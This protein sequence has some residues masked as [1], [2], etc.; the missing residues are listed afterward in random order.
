MPSLAL[1]GGKPVRTRPYPDYNTIG[2]EEKDAVMQ[3]MDSGILSGYL[4][5]WSP[6]FYGGPMV[7][8]LERQWEE[9]FNIAHAVSV[10]SAT[11]ALTIAVGALDIGPGDEVIVSPFTMTASVSCVLMFNAIPVFAD[12]SP[13]TYCLS[14]DSIREKITDRTKAI[15]VVDLFGHPFEADAI[16]SIAKKFDLKVI[17]DA[18]Q[19]YGAKYKGHFAGTLA[20]IGVYSLNV[21]KTINCGEGGICVTENEGLAEKMQLIRNHG[22]EVVKLKG[23]QNIVNVVGQNY[24]MCEI[25]AAISS[26]QLKKVDKLVNARIENAEYLTDRLKEFPGITPPIVKE[27]IIHGYYGYPI[28]FDKVKVGLSIDLFVKALVAEGLIIGAGYVEPIY[29]QPLFQ[30]QI[31]YGEKGCPF[32]CGYYIGGK[33]N[34]AKG[35]CPVAERMHN[36]EWMGLQ[37]IHQ[38]VSKSDLDDMILSFGKVFNNIKK[39]RKLK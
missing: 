39:L 8:K 32:T 6:E 36:E 35:I 14:P 29:L 15:I 20:D 30:K 28:R 24:R 16:M 26:E 31:A 38:G 3:V 27:G 19:A 4:G 7:Q 18:A 17:E 23:V 33:V 10:N 13:E 21:H 34:Y 9:Y 12:I 25:E 2:K 11:T 22:E 1:L 5:T 37:P